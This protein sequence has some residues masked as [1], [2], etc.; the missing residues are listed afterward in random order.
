MNQKIKDMIYK[1]IK[2]DD[3]TNDCIDEVLEP[4]LKEAV[5]KSPTTLDDLALAKFY[6]D[7]EEIVK[8]KVKEYY[9]KLLGQN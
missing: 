4:A 7:L 9:A 1:N 3:L 6:P 8:L 2:L 5:K